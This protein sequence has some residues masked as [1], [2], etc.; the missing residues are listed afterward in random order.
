MTKWNLP[1][2][3]DNLSR[4]HMDIADGIYLQN[5]SIAEIRERVQQNDVITFPIGSTENHGLK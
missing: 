3:A 5:M 1:P 4:G 2:P